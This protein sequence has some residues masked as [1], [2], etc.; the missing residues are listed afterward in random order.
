VSTLRSDAQRN[1]ERVL[2]AAAET[3]AERGPDASIDEIARRAGVGHATVFRRFPTKDS[4]IEAVVQDRIHQLEALADAAL[5]REDAGAAFTD[6]IW[7]VAEVQMTARGLH[8]CL[9]HCEAPDKA[10]LEAAAEHIVAR[11]QDAGAVRSDLAPGDVAP[12]IR[13]ALE[14]APAERWQPYLR[15]VLDGLRL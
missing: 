3:F 8:A 13:A 6:F 14:A 9:V 7:Q 15:V 12:L 2:H 1:L 5:E 4:L 10:K 11:A